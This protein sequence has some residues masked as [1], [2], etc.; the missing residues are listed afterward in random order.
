[1]EIISETAQKQGWTEIFIF[2]FQKSGCVDKA[3]VCSRESGIDC[4]NFLNSNYSSHLKAIVS[5]R[6]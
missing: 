3:S 5:V 1:M 2:V 6:H 4:R